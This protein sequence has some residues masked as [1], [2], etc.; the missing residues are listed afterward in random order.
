MGGTSTGAA[1]SGIGRPSILMV[2]D[3]DGAGQ[4]LVRGLTD[5]Y[6]LHVVKDT[7]EAR[8]RLRI[9]YADVVLLELNSPARH[10]P[11]FEFLDHLRAEYPEI[12]V[13]LLSARPEAATIVRAMKLGAT[14]Y[15]TLD[16]GAAELELNLRTAQELRASRIRVQLRGDGEEASIVGNS[17]AISALRMELKRLAAVER[18][19]LLTGEVGTGKELFARALHAHGPHPDEPFVV[20]NCAAFTP[21]LLEQE[22]FGN[23][24]GAFE[25]AQRRRI[26]RFQEAGQGT[27]YLDE[28]AKMSLETQTKLQLA[29]SSGRFRPLG[30]RQEVPLRARVIV[31][32]SR[33]LV[34]EAREGRFHNVLLFTLRALELR[35]PPLRERMED[36]EPLTHHLIFRKAQEM[37]L[38]VPTLEVAALKKLQRQSWPGNVR[39]L[40]T[41]IENAL[42]HLD[43]NSLSPK[44]F[45]LLDCG[46]YEGLGYHE[47][48]AQADEGFRLAYYKSLLQVT[49]GN[50]AEMMAISGLPR[51]T[52]HRHLVD[53]GLKRKDF[54]RR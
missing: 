46:G 41:V 21:A 44:C 26:G 52:I 28:I 20:V 8:E 40:A 38:P 27:L 51:Q 39:E 36:L 19:L 11:G 29:L 47:A 10:A 34:R 42:V 22:L 49:R 9:R 15:V 4:T 6:S 16:A 48:K 7:D 54:K 30:T 3:G 25:G 5:R 2:E 31:G 43:G 24:R 12:P 33:D 32:S 23:E 14:G 35:I 1:E 45:K 13:L 18:P 37:K 17:P 50:M 53:L